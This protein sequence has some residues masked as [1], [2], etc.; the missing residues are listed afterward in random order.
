MFSR[1]SVKKPFTI[2]VAVIIVLVLGFV[3][4][5]SMTP[6]LLPNMDFPTVMVMTT[7]AG[8][9]PEEIE[10]AVSSPLEEVFQTI[11]KVDEVSSTSS[12]NYS[13]ITIS[14]NEDANMDTITADI[15]EK[16]NTVN[17]DWD[18]KIGNPYILKINMDIMPAV[19][20]SVTVDGMDQIELSNY[21]NDTLLPKLRGIDGVASVNLNGIVEQE[22]TV[23]LDEDKINSLNKKI[24]K[25]IDKM[26]EEGE[27]E[28]NDA[29]KEIEDGQN[30]LDEAQDQISSGK[31]G[32]DEARNQLGSQLADAETELSKKERELIT[33]KLSLLDRLSELEGQKADLEGTKEQLLLIKEPLD[34]LML[35]KEI[36]EQTVEELTEIQGNLEE[37]EALEA[38][39]EEQIAAIENNSS[40]SDED[41]IILIANIVASDDYVQMQEGFSQIDSVLGE[42][43]YTRDE[44]ALRLLESQAALT[45]TETSISAIDQLLGEMGL[46]YDEISSTMAQ[47]DE[48]ILQIEEG[49]ET[50]NSTYGQLD[51]GLLAIDDAKRELSSQKTSG[52]IELSSSL[53]TLLLSEGTLNSTKK[54]LEGAL[55]QVKTAQ[56]ELDS[57]KETA[58]N[59]ADLNKALTTDTI[60]QLLTAQ[61][62]AMPAGYIKNDGKNTLVRVGNKIEDLDELKNLLIYNSDLDGVDSIYLKDVADI[63]LTDNSAETYAKLDGQDGILLTFSK[64]SNYATADVSNN[65]AKMLEEIQ[66]ESPEITFTSLL[67]QGDYIYIVINSVLESLVLGGI[68]AVIILIFFLKDIKPTF[69]VACSIPISVIFTIVLMYFSGITLNIIS[70]SGLSVGIGMLVDN[71]IVVIENIYRLRKQ[72]ASAVKAAVSGA[73]QVS[74]AIVASTVTTVCVFLPIIFMQGMTKQI[75]T[76]MALT[77]GYSLFASLLIALTVVPAMSQGMLKNTKDRKDVFFNKVV[78]VYKRSL[79]FTLRH[80]IATVAV[81]LVIFALSIVSVIPR[82]FTFMPTMESTSV[83]VT[84]SLPED[85]TFEET[86]EVGDE[87]REIASQFDD[88]ETVGVMSGQLTSV[89]GLDFGGGSADAQNL[90]MYLITKEDKKLSTEELG[91]QLIEKC[92]HIDAEI[93]V[94]GGMSMGSFSSLS[95]DTVGMNVYS[96]DLDTLQ[97]SAKDIAKV[98]EGVEGVKS[99]SDGIDETTPEIR[100]VVDKDKAMKEGL[101]VAQIYLDIQQ[102]LAGESTATEISLDS[103]ST[104]IVISNGNKDEITVKDIENHIIKATDLQGEEKDV[105]LLDVADIEYTHTLESIGHRLQKR[106]L[107][108]S[109][110]LEPGYN[111]TNVANSIQT[112]LDADFDA[113]AGVTLEATGGSETTMEAIYE[114]VKMLGLAIILIYLVMVA[115]FQSLRSP[116]IVMFTIPLAFTGGLLALFFFGETISVVAMIGFVMLAGIVVNNGIVLI[117]YMNQL[118]SVGAGRTEAA[119]IAGQTRLRPVLMTTL[120]TVLALVPMAIGT[121]MG[122]EMMQP[123]ALTCIGGLLYATLLTLY[124]V[125]IIYQVFSRKKFRVLDRDD[126]KIMEENEAEEDFLRIELEG[127]REMRKKS[128]RENSL[129]DE[130][131]A[132]PYIDNPTEHTSEDINGSLGN[133]T[134]D[135]SDDSE[136]ENISYPSDETNEQHLNTESEMTENRENNNQ[137]NKQSRK[138]NKKRGRRDNRKE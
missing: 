102:M 120:T 16:I 10:A 112:A 8:Y 43:G 134:V 125:P 131:E 58:L 67:D 45:L 63:A 17:S 57:Q 115:Q 66:N 119:I 137:N 87:I 33:T 92:K 50:I 93:S 24:E 95:S 82:G 110:E 32:I 3:S 60:T 69:I 85:N 127:S 121:G 78:K 122:S 88:V 70:L 56:D 116:L 44:V 114:V 49:I 98:I 62:F 100:I 46:S 103:V 51:S 31:E 65:V 48:G 23:T 124:I 75:F 81:V 13:L 106:Y 133:N 135:Y 18:E 42:Y 126:L 64:Q 138:H 35:R 28:L 22:I 26:F 37:L 21:V 6:N 47:I 97:A 105:K 11:D 71:S 25:A 38:Y 12:E 76:D 53:T 7:A 99:V 30:E 90:T 41:K 89:I 96:E 129:T 91:S 20:S 40:L 39:F 130:N 2:F 128:R 80:K 15:R 132:E 29:E 111:A 123:I 36:L 59:S 86:T 61:N 79:E 19:V 113:P 104:D 68:L 55:S 118:R 54:E 94:T 72:G 4:L 5:Q 84:I 108:V 27:K 109:A 101:T 1:F 83:Y 107:E 74:G 117:D 77:I 34:E 73:V 9:S 52:T 136:T 14:F